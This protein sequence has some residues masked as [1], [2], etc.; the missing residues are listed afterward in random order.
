[1]QSRIN[2]L[3]VSFLLI[4]LFSCKTAEFHHAQIDV[5]GMVYDF[6]NRPVANYTVS[7]DE[8][9]SAVTDVTGRF[10]FSSIPS[11]LYT[12]SGYAEGFERYESAVII[13]SKTDIMY[14]RV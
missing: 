9:I 3:A 12:L 13:E 7:L 6:E 2:K 1:M 5:H 4:L 14:L 10:S 11:G 8:N